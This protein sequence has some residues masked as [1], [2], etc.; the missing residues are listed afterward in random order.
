MSR[1]ALAGP[2]AITLLGQTTDKLDLSS[3]LSRIVLHFRSVTNEFWHMLFARFHI[4][5]PIDPELL[6]ILALVIMPTLFQKRSFAKQQDGGFYTNISLGFVY[7]ICVAMIPPPITG[8][9][10]LLSAWFAMAGLLFSP[11]KAA[12]FREMRELRGRRFDGFWFLVKSL[13]WLGLT[14][15]LLSRPLTE[16]FHFFT[17]TQQLISAVSWVLAVVAVMMIAVRKIAEGA[18]GPFYIVL[19]GTGIFLIDWFATIAKPAMEAWLTSVG[20]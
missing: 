2:G 14:L 19:M 3:I 12:Y 10:I 20:A 1:L 16:T 15:I 11:E 4:L 9:L 6:T 18:P 17:D 5:L 7:L 13:F 8:K